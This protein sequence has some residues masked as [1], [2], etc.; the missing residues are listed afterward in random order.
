MVGRPH[1]P[2]MQRVK[3]STPHCIPQNWGAAFWEYSLAGVAGRRGVALHS[4]TPTTET[5]QKVAPQFRGI[6][7]GVLLF[8]LRMAGWWWLVWCTHHLSQHKGPGC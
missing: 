5:R 1:R 4:A 3:N 6:Q 7:C 8:T 2:T